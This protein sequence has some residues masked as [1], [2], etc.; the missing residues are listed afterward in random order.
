MR[1]IYKP[2]HRIVHKACVSMA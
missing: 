1:F 2:A